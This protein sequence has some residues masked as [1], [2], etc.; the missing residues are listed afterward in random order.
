MKR[1]IFCLE[2]QWESDLEDRCSVLP[3]LDTLER[4]GRSK[5]IHRDVGTPDGS[6]VATA[7]RSAGW[8]QPVST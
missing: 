1:R 7:S 8:S 3:T 4:L 2:G 6:S 5:Y